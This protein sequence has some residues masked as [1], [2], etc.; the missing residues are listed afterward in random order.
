MRHVACLLSAALVCASV[1]AGEEQDRAEEQATNRCAQRKAERSLRAERGERANTL[2][3]LEAAFPGKVTR[4]EPGKNEDEGAAWFTL[5]AGNSDE[6][7]KTDAVAAGLGPMF[8]RW[9]QRLELGP[10]PSIKHDEF[11]KFAKLIIRNAAQAQG[12]EVNTNDDADKMFRVLDLNSDGELTGSELSSALRDDKAQADTNGDGRISKEEYREYFRRR[13]DKKAETL[14]TALK[15]NEDTIRNLNTDK[16]TGLPDWF[17]KLDTDKDGQISLAQWRKAGKDIA[18][19][20]EMD[21]NGDGLLTRDEYLR[22][23][24]LKEAA[25]E[26]KR[27]D[28]KK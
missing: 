18:L 9:V 22:W 6:W 27:K 17:T 26:Q 19:F 20:E 14:T 1:H 16:R 23:A 24:K 2:R 4:T 11:L 12:E 8:E 7:K 13:V 28:E 15:T 21:L 3:D 5:V 10:V 25:A